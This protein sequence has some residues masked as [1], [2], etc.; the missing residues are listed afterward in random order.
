[1][2][3]TETVDRILRMRGDGLPVLSLYVRFDPADRRGFPRRVGEQLHA[4]RLLAKDPR[5]S[6]TPGCRCVVTWS[7]SRKPYGRSA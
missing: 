7:A 6:M 3:Q 2:L 5:W 4:V 1:M